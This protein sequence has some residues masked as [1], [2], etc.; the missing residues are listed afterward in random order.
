PHFHYHFLPRNREQTI[1]HDMK[2]GQERV[3]IHP[4]GKIRSKGIITKQ[5]LIKTN[6]D[7]RELFNQNPVLRN[8]D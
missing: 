1:T 8:I 4:K 7:L 2:N 6:N 5:R 3:Q